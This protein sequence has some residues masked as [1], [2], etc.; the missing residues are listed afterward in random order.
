MAKCMKCGRGGMG[1]LHSAI[2]LKDKNF[3]CVKCYKELGGN[4]LKD[5]T[6]APTLYTWDDIKDG[7]DAMYSKKSGPTRSNLEEYKAHGISYD[8]EDGHNIQ[9]LLSAFVKSEYED[10]KLTASEVKEELEYDDRVYLYPTMDINVILEPTEFD[11]EPAVKVMGE[12]SPTV[13]QH[14]GW[15]PKRDAAHVIEIL[16]NYDYNVSA[17]LVGGPYKYRD[18]D[19]KIRSDS[20]EFG[21]RIYLTY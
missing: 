2:R 3:V 21:C 10:D 11:G 19:D 14:I 1:V 5:M 4:P 18:D 7:F 6:K 15:I 8:N 20:T 17:E 16:N 12:V 9:K 13:Y